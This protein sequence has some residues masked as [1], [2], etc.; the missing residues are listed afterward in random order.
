MA[1]IAIYDS[2]DL[3]KAQLVKYLEKTDHKW[4]FIK[5]SISLDNIKPEA[6]V[7]SP[8]VS[9]AVTREM[10]EKMPK[11]K[12]IAC[13][14][15]GFNNIDLVAAAEHGV[16]V[17]NV[18]SYG[19]NTVA[20]YTFGLILV[21][22]RKIREA[23]RA[24]HRG[25]IEL[26]SMVGFDLKGKTIGIIGIGHIGQQVAR[27]A[28]GF[29]LNIL[30][31]DLYPNKD[32]A[33]E[34]NLSY[35]SLDK[36]LHDSD[37][38]TLH[39][40]YTGSNHYLVNA[41]FLAKTKPGA[42]LV[43]TSRGELLDNQALIDA[44]DSKQIGCAALDV[45]EGEQLLDSHEEAA[46]LR[47]PNASQ[48]NLLKFGA[49]VEILKSYDNVL[50]SPH[51]AF[52]TTEAIDRINQTTADNIIQFWHGKSPNKIN[53]PTKA[54]GKLI[55]VRHGESEWNALGKWTGKTE[56]HLSEN[57]FH[58]AAELGQLAQDI[59]FDYAFC[60]NQ[61]RAFETLQGILSAAQQIDV[62]YEKSAA[63][64][65]RDYGDYT[66][67]NK[68]E[69]RDKVGQAEFDSL[70]R[71][72]DRPLPNGESLKMVYARVEPYYKDTILPKVLDGKNVLVVA[73]GNSIR[74]MVKYIE[75]ITN[76]AISDF[77]MPIGQILIYDIDEAGYMT[78]KAERKIETKPSKA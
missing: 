72:W 63:I 70:R 69:I 26:G 48:A 39:M 64:N 44:L 7:I 15:T 17:V 67:S 59:K 58:Q 74:S 8:F 37:I 18:P 31:Y 14:S 40:P 56:V 53:N 51:N 10:I 47:H 6:E 36:L 25:D 16:T 42:M 1:Y 46:I 66:G 19:E 5:K 60:S 12:L 29:G 62:P 75:K 33:K 54:Y 9:S 35:V 57:G 73:H 52:N 65:E 32:A 27:I 77:E 71:D 13:R 30:A 50:I 78:K 68:W 76:Q 4:D 55:L 34:F 2:T 45:L 24:V 23:T 61:I 28:N 38:I 3:D 43:N 49:Q 22:S 11:L 41:E 20:E 21:L